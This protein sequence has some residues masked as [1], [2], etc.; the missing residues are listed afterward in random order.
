MKL[1]FS[2]IIF[3]LLLTSCS[4]L[5]QVNTH[6][7]I[8]KRKYT[9]G[10]FIDNGRTNKSLSKRFLSAQNKNSTSMLYNKPC[11]DT[12]YFV[13]GSTQM[14]SVINI[15]VNFLDVYNCQENKVQHLAKKTLDSILYAKGEIWRNGNPEVIV[16]ATGHKTIYMLDSTIHKGELGKY[17]NT[18]KEVDVS[19]ENSSSALILLK[20]DIVKIEHANGYTEDLRSESNTLKIRGLQKNV[21]RKQILMF[22]IGMLLSFAILFTLLSLLYLIAVVIIG[23]VFVIFLL[24]TI[25]AQVELKEFKRLNPID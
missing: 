7:K 16:E 20:E 23:L 3:L 17:K 2:F 24:K 8:Q 12:L 10:W 13:D 11:S 4:S 19:T 1:F 6:G 25:R 15:G 22:F 5:N 9:H 14:F 18:W 21:L